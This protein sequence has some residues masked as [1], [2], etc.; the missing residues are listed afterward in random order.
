VTN[1]RAETLL[2]KQGIRYER[3]PD[4]IEKGQKPD[5]YCR[6]RSNFWCEVKTLGRL[7]DDE[8]RNRAF[9]ELRNRTS[10]I[11]APGYGIAYIRSALSAR[12]AKAITNLLKRAVPRLDASDSPDVAV[13]MIP[14]DAKRDQFVRFS[15]S[16]EDHG[17]VEFHSAA[18]LSGKYGVPRD[19]TPE[20]CDQIIKLRLSSGSEKELSAKDVIKTPEDFRVAVVVRPDKAPFE[21][22]TVMTTGGARKLDNQGRIRETVGEANDQF[23]NAIYY[24]T[25]PCL[26]MIFQDGLDVPD[27]V[28]IKSALYGNLKYEFP[29]GHP[30]KGRLIADKDGAW[31][32]TKNRTTS[33]VLYVRNSG[34]PLI[35]HNY[36]AARPLPAGLFSCREVAALP[37]G[38]F[39]EVTF[40][41][42]IAGWI[43]NCRRWSFRAM[44]KRRAR[45]AELE[46]RRA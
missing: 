2:D 7:P 37:N 20:P 34:E 27:E 42:G 11:S 19:M 39:D 25:G 8:D 6:G 43:P 21:I 41:P 29:K 17:T 46:R 26:L 3:E 40:P 10:S 31:N 32:S 23:K 44:Q 13:A 16:T 5:F 30:E 12:D 9:T 35:I 1:A 24:R 18:S 45:S 22:G 28:I 33:A 4:W 38:T 15:L 36:W 14:G